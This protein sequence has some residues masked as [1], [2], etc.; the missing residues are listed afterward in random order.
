MAST[1]LLDEAMHKSSVKV[2]VGTPNLCTIQGLSGDTRKQKKLLLVGYLHLRLTN[3]L[4]L[5]LLV[6]L[7]GRTT[8]GLYM[9]PQCLNV[10][11]F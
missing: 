10:F 11:M 6:A 5:H 1:P 4:L 7:I 8:C 3:L 9:I 2:G